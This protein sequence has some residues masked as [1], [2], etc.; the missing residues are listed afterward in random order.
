MTFQQMQYFIE[1][2]HCRNFTKAAQNL[3]IAQPN[4]TK[5][6]ANMEK[7][8]GFKLFERSARKVE[9]T[10]EGRVLLQKTETIFAYLMRA[11]EDTKIMSKQVVHPINIGI[12]RDETVPEAVLQL[13][14]EI[15]SQADIHI[16]LEQDSYQSLVSRLAD[17][18]YDLILTTDRNVRNRSDIEFEPLRPFNL[19]I[20]LHR[21]H[22]KAQI[23]DLSPRDLRGEL[24]FLALPDGKTAPSGVV[25]LVYHNCGGNGGE[26]D[27]QLCNSPSDTILNALINSGI[28]IVSGLVNRDDFPDIRFVDFEE[29]TDA[30]Q[31]V[32]WRKDESDSAV[33]ACRDLIIARCRQ[34]DEL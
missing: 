31:Y 17:H 15:N 21:T 18:T 10:P 16:V 22:P 4:L 5:Y 32:A 9:L 34:A 14:R 29:R 13:L 33:L 23:E 8:L 25:S 12:S 19:V 26:F 11:V 7:E 24:V 6:I 30:F 28:A 3:Y 27:I 1:V 2:A 20:A